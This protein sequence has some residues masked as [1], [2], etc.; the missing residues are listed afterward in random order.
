VNLRSRQYG[1]LAFNNE[2]GDNRKNCYG[3]EGN[4]ET[5]RNA[6]LEV[7]PPRQMGTPELRAARKRLRSKFSK[8]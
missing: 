4:T 2:V 3:A 8:G 7:A 5:A 6:E 1:H